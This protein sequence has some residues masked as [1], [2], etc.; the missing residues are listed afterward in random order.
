MIGNVRMEITND[1]SRR[2]QEIVFAKG[3]SW[4][5]GHTDVH[6]TDVK[7]LYIAE[8]KTIS[9]GTSH[10]CFAAAKEEEISAYD[11][12]TSQ[13]QQKWLPKYGEEVHMWNYD[14]ECKEKVKFSSYN[15][16]S[17]SKYISTGGVWYRHC[18]PIRD[19][20]ISFTT[21]SGEN[22]YVTISEEEMLKLMS[23]LYKDT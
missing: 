6:D 16:T 22:I 17:T 10:S 1:L 2:V 13:G 11:F 4:S 23:Q 18:A 21:V 12:V 5:S 15:F 3:G 20:E 19:K 14:E 9:L 7:Y 8:N